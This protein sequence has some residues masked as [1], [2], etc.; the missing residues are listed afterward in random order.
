MNS[1]QI[2]MTS[3][4]L[5]S[6]AREV[7]ELILAK[8]SKEDVTRALYDLMDIVKELENEYIEEL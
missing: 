3:S 6:C 8:A 1:D 4:D 2:A 5:V 7:M